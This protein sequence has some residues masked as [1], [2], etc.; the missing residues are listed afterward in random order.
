MLLQSDFEIAPCLG[1]SAIDSSAQAAVLAARSLG[2]TRSASLTR[3]WSVP[4]LFH[5]MERIFAS[6]EEPI[7]AIN[8]LLETLVEFLTAAS[9][10]GF[11]DLRHLQG[12]D[13]PQHLDSFHKSVEGS[14]GEHYGRLFE[15]FSPQSFWEEPVRLLSLRLERNG[16]NIS[17][18]KNTDVL[19]AGCGGGRYT[20]A[21]RLLGAKRVVGMDIS[22][23]GIA[24]AEERVMKGR[25]EG[26]IF[27]Q[28]NV[29][30][31][32]FAE[33]SVDVAF[34]NG[35]LHHTVDWRLGV[36]ELMRV[37]RPGGLGWLYL[38]EKPGGLFWDV[39]EILRVIMGRERPDMARVTLRMLGIPANRIFYML[40]P[41]MVP[42]NMRLSR[43]EVE[44]CLAAAGARDVRRLSRGADFDRV[45]RIF[46]GEPFASVKYGVGENRYVFSKG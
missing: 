16:I 28:G 7:A 27:Q 17:K 8:H 9:K 46:T 19:D 24:N 41:V 32:P 30:A 6:D 25:I 44:E 38:M 3:A 26:V 1:E 12:C 13:L 29:L 10:N 43:D 18:L 37:L 21:W 39:I 45:E 23:V 31:L 34:S 2:V 40:D 20:V 15:A 14:T 5:G 33:N 4:Y 22:P 35:V 36:A 42:I 11:A